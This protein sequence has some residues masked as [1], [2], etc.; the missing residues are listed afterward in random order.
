M[1]SK[2]LLLFSLL[3]GIHQGIKAQTIV[4]HLSGIYSSGCFNVTGSVS[5][6]V[7]ASAQPFIPYTDTVEF[8][9]DYGD[10]TPVQTFNQ[11]VFP[12]LNFIGN[13]AQCYL[14]HTYS[15][16]GAYTITVIANFP[17]NTTDTL[18]WVNGATLTANCNNLTG[19][20]YRDNNSNCTFDAGDDSLSSSIIRLW[21][22]DYEA[23]QFIYTNSGGE[24]TSSVLSGINYK[25]QPE[26]YTGTGYRIPEL[27]C[28]LTD[29]FAFTASSS[30][31]ID[32][33][34]RDTN[35]FVFSG[36]DDSAGT[37]CYNSVNGTVLLRA[38]T[39]F[40]SDVA[41]PNIQA[42]VFF[43]DGNDS[44][45]SPYLYM[46]GPFAQGSYYL[47]HQYPGPGIYSVMMIVTELTTGLTDT[48]QMPNV[49]DL[50]DS[51]GAISGYLYL[52]NNTNCQYDQ[53]E[54]ISY[55]GA[56][57][58]F[59]N[60]T[61]VTIDY[62]DSS[63]YYSIDLLPGTYTVSEMNMIAF[64]GYTMTCSQSPAVTAVV[65]PSVT[66]TQDFGFICPAGYDAEAVLFGVSMRPATSRTIWGG[67][68]T[69]NCQA[70]ADSGYITLV[71]DPLTSFAGFCDTTISYTISGNTVTWSYSTA[72]NNLFLFD[73]D[74]IHIY[75]DS[76]A[77]IGDT[78]CFSLSVSTSLTD[79]NPAN[80]T[81]SICLPVTNSY[82]PNIKQVRAPGMLANGDVLNNRTHEYTIHFQNT[83]NDV[84]YN[85]FILDTLDSDLNPATLQ[86]IGSTH[87]MEVDY[88][89]GDVLKFN[90]NNI[91]LPDSNSNEPL[92]HGWL[93]Y[94]IAQDANLPVNTIITNT[95]HIYFDINPAIVT[96][97]TVNTIINPQSIAEQPLLRGEVYPVPASEFVQVNINKPVS[98]TLVLYNM[99]G[100]PVLSQPINASTAVIDVH[101]L[102]AGIYQLQI[103]TAEGNFN[104]PVMIQR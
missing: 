83:G 29:S 14:S 72:A 12:N 66:I 79:I 10:A 99:L 53:G 68:M 77:Q 56:V 85:I 13:Y 18:I 15:A 32:F 47:T 41:N 96:N 45:F 21:A 23:G 26:I 25:I 48:I 81:T 65:T 3:L 74:C 20:I 8:I 78:L 64:Y 36:I 34:L 93:R 38:F 88:L 27:S 75:T 28:S 1:K 80:N 102:P 43:G 2:L 17:N 40:Y 58:V 42:H 90:F 97:T 94:T 11:I 19:R 92:S 7:L 55:G 71:L 57:A 82:D 76:S 63:G 84:V 4:P 62:T 24:Y 49:V 69:Q 100:Q 73:W 54:G 33:P 89:S 5:G 61:L 86:I 6:S 46:D 16:P 51:C 98:G 44:I 103:I 87:T 95:A 60:N 91:N 30:N 104:R 37:I 59:Q 22:N 52:D 50:N 67:L 31:V 101:L 35:M 39:M 70:N 9:V